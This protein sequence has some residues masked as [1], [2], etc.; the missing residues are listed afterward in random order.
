MAVT[1]VPACAARCPFVGELVAELARA[2]GTSEDVQRVTHGLPGED[3]RPQSD[4][5]D[6]KAA[7]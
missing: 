6:G 5:H 1:S 4:T 3:H 2:R 7:T